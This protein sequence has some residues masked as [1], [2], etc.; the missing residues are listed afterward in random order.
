MFILNLF[1]KSNSEKE[2]EKLDKIHFKID[3]NENVPKMQDWSEH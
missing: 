2:Q 3:L 1:G